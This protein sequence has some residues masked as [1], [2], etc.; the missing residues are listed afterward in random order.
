MPAQTETT[1]DNIHAGDSADLLTDM[2]PE[3]LEH[4]L[5]FVR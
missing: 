2:P 1:E 5:S 3:L 4:I